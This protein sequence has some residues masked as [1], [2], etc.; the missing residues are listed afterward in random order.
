MPPTEARVPLQ[1]KCIVK[2]IIAE[3]R[4]CSDISRA[5]AVHD[6]LGVATNPN[7]HQ[8]QHALQPI[9]HQNLRCEAPTINGYVGAWSLK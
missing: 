9:V 7:A 5:A 3:I 1:Q 2:L 6:S 4:L 8:P